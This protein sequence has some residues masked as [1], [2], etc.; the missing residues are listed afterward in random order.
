MPVRKPSCLFVLI[1]IIGEPFVVR[2]FS[3]FPT[4]KEACELAGR[5]FHRS[6]KDLRPVGEK[7]AGGVALI[8]A[9]TPADLSLA[10][11]A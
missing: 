10:R 2:S 6:R 5:A 8:S 7:F 3:F 11:V 4:L 9:R 1:E